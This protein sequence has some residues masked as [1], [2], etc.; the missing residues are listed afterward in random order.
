M[1]E[2]TNATAAD[3]QHLEGQI[4]NLRSQLEEARDQAELNLLMLQKVQEELE[5][6]YLAQQQQEQLV[7]RQREQLQRAEGL[8]EALLERVERQG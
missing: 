1:S 2:P 3:P 6:T 4:V 5:I 8:I 7:Q